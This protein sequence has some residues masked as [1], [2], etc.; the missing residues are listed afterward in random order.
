MGQKYAEYD[1]AGSIFAFYD[2][3]DSPP[4]DDASVAEITVEEWQT[5]LAAPGYTI[6]S[7]A[8]VAPPPPTVTAP[9]PAEI[10][11]ANTSTLAGLQATAAVAIAPLNLSVSLGDATDEEIASAKL[12]QAYSRALKAVSLTTQSPAWPAVPV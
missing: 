8:L 3:V 4:P 2:S 10:L 9:T 6:V 5:C 1:S 7:G 11:A 12:W